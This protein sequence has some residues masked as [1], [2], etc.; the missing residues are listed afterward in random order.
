MSIVELLFI[1]E[2]HITFY[3]KLQFDKKLTCIRYFLLSRDIVLT[4]EMQFIAH[5]KGKKHTIID[6]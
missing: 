3:E 1:N 4:N 2:N 6:Y 5:W